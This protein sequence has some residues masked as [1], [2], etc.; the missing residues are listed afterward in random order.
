MKTKI[1]KG[2][3]T[4]EYVEKNIDQT[5]IFGDNNA[6]IGKGGQ[7]I[8]RDLPNTMGIRTKKGPSTK[9][10]AYYKDSEYEQNCRNILED[11][12]E[13]KEEALKGSTIVFSDGGY[14]TGLASLKQKAPKTFEFLCQVLKDHLNFDNERGTKWNKIP[15]HNDITSGAYVSLDKENGD[16]LQPINNSY[17]RSD[18]LEKGLNTIFDLIRTDNKVAFTSSKQYQNDDVIIFTF[19]GK[20]HLVCR[21]ICS[22]SVQDVLKDYR[23][24]SFEGFDKTFSI[25]GPEAAMKYQTHFQFICTLDDKGN[26]VFRNDIFG[27]KKKAISSSNVEETKEE[28]KTKDNVK[29]VHIKKEDNKMSV[30]NEEI[31]EV[32]KR[33]EG[34][35]NSK[36]IFFKN[37]FKKKTLEELANHKIGKVISIKHL[38][39]ISSNNKYQI[40]VEGDSFYLVNFNKGLFRNSIEIILNSKTSIG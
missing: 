27:E 32:L 2:N 31:L 36:R 10:V 6:R 18:F 21:A 24:Y 1:H 20:K 40:E 38:E 13:I 28:L 4:R 26:M 37:P 23:W 3:W 25:A 16:I 34:K 22:Y 17:F 9:S 30:S 8:I 15:G 12:L 14:G 11:I 35:M 33:I 19:S 5:F 29:V 7:A 39:T